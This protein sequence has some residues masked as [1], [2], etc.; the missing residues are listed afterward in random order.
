VE[1]ELLGKVV[2]VGPA[3]LTMVFPTTRC[4]ATEVDPVTAERDLPIPRML[5]QDYGDAVLGIYGEVTT[6]GIVRAGQAV[7]VE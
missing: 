5:V 4:A 3:R 7:S 1:R 2:R 6:G